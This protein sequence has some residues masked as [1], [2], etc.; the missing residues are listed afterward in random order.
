MGRA[1]VLACV[2]LHVCLCVHTCE[3]ERLREGV[4]RKFLLL[5]SQIRRVGVDIQIRKIDRSS[6]IRHDPRV[7]TS[8]LASGWCEMCLGAVKKRCEMC[9]GGVSQNEQRKVD[10]SPRLDVSSVLVTEKRF[11]RRWVKQNV[12]ST[13]SKIIGI[14][15]G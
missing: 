6:V 1:C 9:L 5:R 10:A 8:E 11:G 4:G 7:S 13:C 12:L 3:R 2:R 14:D 15:L